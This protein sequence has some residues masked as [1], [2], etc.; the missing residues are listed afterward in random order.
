MPEAPKPTLDASKKGKRSRRKGARL[1]VEFAQIVGGIVVRLS[2]ALRGDTKSNDVIQPEFGDDWRYE[3]KGRGSGLK[4]LYRWLRRE[5]SHGVQTVKHTPEATPVAQGG[6]GK[7]RPPQALAVRAD[8]SNWLVV[9]PLDEWLR[10]L[11]LFGLARQ[12]AER[13]W[14]ERAIDGLRKLKE[15]S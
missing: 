3:V 2:G 7:M 4:T 14:I 10:L 9:I 13:G 1:E 8:N 15:V 11:D 6:L 12:E 5:M